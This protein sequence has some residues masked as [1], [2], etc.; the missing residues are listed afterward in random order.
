M[1][2]A[3]LHRTKGASLTLV[4]KRDSDTQ[5]ARDSIRQ[6]DAAARK[7]RRTKKSCALQPMLNVSQ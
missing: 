4:L 5:E 6:K 2:T 1:C 7:R 3:I